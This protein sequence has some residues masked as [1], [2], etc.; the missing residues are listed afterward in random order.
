MA[1]PVLAVRTERNQENS[2]SA[3]KSA[4]RI[5]NENYKSKSTYKLSQQ[6]D[7]QIFDR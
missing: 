3:E 2:K 5:E 4:K 6:E 7:G 1:S